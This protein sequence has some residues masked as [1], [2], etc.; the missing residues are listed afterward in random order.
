MQRTCSRNT[1]SPPRNPNLSALPFL[2]HIPLSLCI[3]Q[4][5]IYLPLWKPQDVKGR[6]LIYW[7]NVTQRTILSP[8]PSLK[9]KKKGRASWA[10]RDTSCFPLLKASWIDETGIKGT[11]CLW[12]FGTGRM[13]FNPLLSPAPECHRHFPPSISWVDLTS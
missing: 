9:K 1:C 4:E 8:P 5:A 11:V 10:I 6:R 7:Q 2:D 12:G 3:E 13:A